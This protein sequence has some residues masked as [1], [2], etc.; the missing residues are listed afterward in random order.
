MGP[1]NNVIFCELSKKVNSVY[2]F[3]S[4]RL[5]VSLKWKLL[6]KKAYMAHIVGSDRKV[7]E[8]YGIVRKQPLRRIN[9]TE[10][11]LVNLING[12]DELET[13]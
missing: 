9:R 12:D 5:E 13:L 7:T 4:K 2:L 11:D 6:H 1:K 8:V 10:L 3:V